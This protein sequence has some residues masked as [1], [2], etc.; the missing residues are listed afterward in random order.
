MANSH[1]QKVVIARRLTGQGL[2]QDED[3]KGMF[4][5]GPWNARAEAIRARVARKQGFAH[6]RALARQQVKIL[7]RQAAHV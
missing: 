6:K 1:K 3:W 2:N 5:N 7:Q 4:N